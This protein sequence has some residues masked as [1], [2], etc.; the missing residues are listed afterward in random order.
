MNDL[1]EKLKD[2][3]QAMPFWMRTEA[4]REVLMKAAPNGLLWTDKRVWPAWKESLT[5]ASQLECNIYI[6]KPDYRPEPEYVDVEIVADGCGQLRLKNSLPGK[7]GMWPIDM[8]VRHKDFDY[9]WYETGPVITS[10]LA[11]H[12]VAPA[13]RKNKKVFARFIE[14]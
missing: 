11:I 6:L 5:R 3:E 9:F 1:I 13:K 4:E 10:H 8:C 12:D 14:E 2:K 7:F